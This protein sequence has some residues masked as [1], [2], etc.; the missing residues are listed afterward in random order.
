MYSQSGTHWEL[1][2]E[3]HI[4]SQWDYQNEMKTPNKWVYYKVGF[5]VSCF[6]VSTSNVSPHKCMTI[7]TKT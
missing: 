7:L 6:Y 5:L 1:Y 3:S 2:W 4:E